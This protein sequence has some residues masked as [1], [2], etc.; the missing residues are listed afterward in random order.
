MSGTEGHVVREETEGLQSK[1][2]ESASLVRS[3]PA[4]SQ[5]RYAAVQAHAPDAVILPAPLTQS[6]SAYSLAWTPHSSYAIKQGA[7]K[8]L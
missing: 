2:T 4:V 1:T 5:Q 7:G 6:L 8:R 3:G